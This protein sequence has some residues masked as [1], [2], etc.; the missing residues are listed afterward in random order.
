MIILL[1]L[2]FGASIFYFFKNRQVVSFQ[3]RSPKLIVVCLVCIYC[4]CMINTIV[5]ANIQDK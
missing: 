5:L 3:T 2:I 4:D 1:T